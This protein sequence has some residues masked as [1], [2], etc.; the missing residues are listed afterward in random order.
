MLLTLSL[1]AAALAAQDGAPA[2]PPVR[3]TDVALLPD[4]DLL[5]AHDDGRILALDPATGQPAGEGTTVFAQHTEAVRALVV[6]PDGET[7]AARLASGDVAIW[8]RR[9]ERGHPDPDA[10]PLAVLAPAE[11][12]SSFGPPGLAWSHD[13]AHLATWAESARPD[14]AGPTQP[15]LWTRA[16]ELIWTGPTARCATLSPSDDHLAYLTEDALHL[17][18][19][20]TDEQRLPLRGAT[21]VAFSPSGKQLAVGGL[22]CRLWIVDV[23]RWTI[24]L[25][26]TFDPRDAFQESKFPTSLR[27]S[28]NGAWVGMMLGKGCLPVVVDPRN[29]AVVWSGGFHGGRM[30]AV[31]PVAW[32][33]DDRLFYSWDPTVLIDP[34]SGEK[35][36]IAGRNEPVF[37]PA[38][39]EVF[40]VASEPLGCFDLA[41]LERIWPK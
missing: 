27:W 39:A 10:A 4:G 28:P 31:F 41:T 1:A 35:A 12:P 22:G 40:F 19:P 33:A 26:T 14:D 5:V 13:G 34:V 15:Q 36:T 24:A 25:E 30:W 20:G 37:A 11:R 8:P 7:V 9:S 3:V 18:W 16:G 38:N 2:P 29:G 21:R 6:D 23:E 32:T 17:T